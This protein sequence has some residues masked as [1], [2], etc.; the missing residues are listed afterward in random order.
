MQFIDFVAPVVRI[1]VFIAVIAAIEWGIPFRQTS[2]NLHRWGINLGLTLCTVIIF[3][4]AFLPIG[5][6]SRFV[7]TNSWG[8]F[9]LVDLPPVVMLVL[10]VIVLDGATYFAHV[11]LHK[12]PILWELHKVHHADDMVDVSTTLRQH[13]LEAVVRVLFLGIVAIGFGIPL[14]VVAVYRLVSSLN[15]LIEHANIW[16]PEPLDK[17]VS[18]LWVTPRMHKIHHSRD[19]R[20]TDSNYGNLLALFDR[21]LGTFTPIVEADSV[22]YGLDNNR[23]NPR[24]N[25]VGDLANPFD[26]TGGLPPF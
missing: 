14:L 7:T 16:T 21:L 25:D 12:T 19:V 26:P 8:L 20:Q 9:Q 17:W 4:I 6:A 3:T 22:S 18:L 24:D 11:L 5:I 13:P 10:G 15:A 2:Y 1:A 23:D